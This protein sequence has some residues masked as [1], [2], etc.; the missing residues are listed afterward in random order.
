VTEPSVLQGI[1]ATSAARRNGRHPPLPAPLTAEFI[2]D[3]AL[4]TLKGRLSDQA[5]GASDACSM[6][7]NSVWAGDRRGRQAPS[8]GCAPWLLTS[9][10][11]GSG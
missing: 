5:E 3:R 4:T 8:L 9:C 7:W 10:R 6:A 1:V 11:F 2:Q